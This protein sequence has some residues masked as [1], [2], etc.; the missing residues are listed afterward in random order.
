MLVKVAPLGERVIEVNVEEGTT[1]IDILRIAGVAVNDR[2]IMVENAD[3]N[4][5]TSVTEDGAVVTLA[6]K[7]KGG[8]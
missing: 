7:M 6:K 3:A 8:R 4:L 5:N 1:V 2:A